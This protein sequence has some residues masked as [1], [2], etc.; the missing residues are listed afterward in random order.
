MQ[1]DIAGQ[2]NIIND[3]ING[4]LQR[5]CNCGFSDANIE[6]G[7]FSC[8]QKDHQ[9]IYRAHILGTATYSAIDLVNLLQS[10]IMTNEA[11]VSLNNFR[12]I[13]DRTCPTRLDTLDDPECPTVDVTPAPTNA[14]SSSS[15]KPG[16]PTTSKKDTDGKGDAQSAGQNSGLSGSTLVIVFIGI[17]IA[18]LLLILIVLIIAVVFWKVNK[19]QKNTKRYLILII[20]TSVIYYN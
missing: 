9:I 16:N 5:R 14:P 7:F 12:M 15:E 19:Q 2:D 4:F 13:L 6:T 1:R 8:G 17:M 20:I 3:Q 11:Y 18:F 10:W